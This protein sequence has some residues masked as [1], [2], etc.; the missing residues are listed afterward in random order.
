MPVRHIPFDIYD[1]DFLIFLDE[2]PKGVSPLLQ[3]T[4]R[5]IFD[6]AQ[7]PHNYEA[8]RIEFIN[9]GDPPNTHGHQL[10][11]ERHG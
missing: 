1:Y 5:S 8:L 10:H 6:I 9:Y 4:W 7:I 2:L 3:Q 11:S